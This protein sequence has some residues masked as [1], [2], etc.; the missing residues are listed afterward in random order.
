MNIDMNSMVKVNG[1]KAMSMPE[2]ADKYGIDILNPAVV[3]ATANLLQ[4][5]G[6]LIVV[7]NTTKEEKLIN[8]AIQEEMFQQTVAHFDA[9]EEA[10]K[11]R[12]R[13]AVLQ[14][15]GTHSFTLSFVNSLDATSFENWVNTLGVTQTGQFQD[16][17]GAVKLAIK[18]VSPQEYTKITN[19]YKADNAIN[20]GMQMTNK[21]VKGTTNTVNYGLTNVVAPTAKIVGE[22]GMNL[23]KGLFH[24]LMK[25]GAGLIN[26]GAKAVTDTK[27]ALVTDPDCLRAVSTLVDTKNN[28]KQ[29]LAKRMNQVNS[30]NGIEML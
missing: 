18:E 8:S 28:A 22:A 3:I 27:T 15:A 24:T 29:Q 6:Q 1:G 26:S 21:V 7:D 16:D 12:Q 5:R 2:F 25:T 19:K 13:Q 10:H 20:A 17:N 23:G 4:K 30:G 9:Q 11:Q 14:E